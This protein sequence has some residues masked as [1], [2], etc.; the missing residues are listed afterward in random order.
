MSLDVIQISLHC[1]AL[2][3]KMESRVIWSQWPSHLC[4][5]I[6]LVESNKFANR[7]DAIN[8][9]GWSFTVG[10]STCQF[11]EMGIKLGACFSPFMLL[12]LRCDGLDFNN[13]KPWSEKTTARKKVHCL[14]QPLVRGL[15]NGLVFYSKS[16]S[17]RKCE[18]KSVGPNKR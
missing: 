16:F 13:K 11:I 15:A 12:F 3:A 9:I 5:P 17:H 4:F 14:K 2:L 18:H 8:K 6:I 7:N 10:L 1:R